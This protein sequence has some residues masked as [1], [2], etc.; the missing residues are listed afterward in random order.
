M[1]LGFVQQVGG[2]VHA[3]DADGVVGEVV[4]FDPVGELAGFVG[5]FD[6]RVVGGHELVDDEWGG[7][8]LPVG[9]EDVEV[10]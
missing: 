5:V 3:G 2:Q 9:G 1:P 6:D 4:Q 10:L 7:A 8:F